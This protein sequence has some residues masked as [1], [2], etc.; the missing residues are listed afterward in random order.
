M[1]L[2]GCRKS[3][4]QPLPTESDHQDGTEH[5]DE[6]ETDERP[7]RINPHGVPFPQLTRRQSGRVMTRDHASDGPE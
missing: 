5:G 4:L 1:G 7:L 6:S 2:P 3:K